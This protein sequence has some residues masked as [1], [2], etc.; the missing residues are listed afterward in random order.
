MGRQM[1]RRGEGSAGDL[2]QE[3]CRGPDTDEGSHQ[4]RGKGV[5]LDPLR[6]LAL[7]PM[8]R[9]ERLGIH[10]PGGFQ[11]QGTGPLSAM[12]HRLSDPVT[13]PPESWFRLGA[14]MVG[15]T[16]RTSIVK[17]GI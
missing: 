6:H 10:V 17:A 16:G 5:V 2:R 15:R 3:S 4:A 11:I 14:I 13:T 8:T 12:T 9:T 7:R 1:G